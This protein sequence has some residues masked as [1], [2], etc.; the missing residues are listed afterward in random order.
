[1]EYLAEEVQEL[2]G[3][4]NSGREKPINFSEI[5]AEN[6]DRQKKHFENYFK[7][8]ENMQHPYLKTELSR[9]FLRRSL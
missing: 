8:L 1:M 4:I 3:S 2:S 7:A 5:S 6:R 9:I